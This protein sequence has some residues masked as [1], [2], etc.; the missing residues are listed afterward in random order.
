MS[1]SDR[2]SSKTYG[3]WRLHAMPRSLF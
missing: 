2:G 3:D 1:I